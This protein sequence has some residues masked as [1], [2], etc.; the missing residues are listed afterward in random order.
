[1]HKEGWIIDGGRIR[2]ARLIEA[3]DWKNMVKLQVCR[4]EFITTADRFLEV[5]PETEREKEAR[6][7]R[8]DREKERA[9]QV[10]CIKEEI[11]ESPISI[12]NLRSALENFNYSLHQ[13]HHRLH[14]WT[15]FKDVVKTFGANGRWM[16]SLPKPPTVSLDTTTPPTHSSDTL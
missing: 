16:Y 7:N 15:E 11:P 9:Y 1:M 5:K 3:Y 13:L 10:S 2:E 12:L 4:G 8:E 14:E 6:L